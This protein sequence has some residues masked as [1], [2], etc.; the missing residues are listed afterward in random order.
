MILFFGLFILFCAAGA[1]VFLLM[2]QKSQGIAKWSR[3][4]GPNVHSGVMCFAVSNRNLF[5]GT[6]R[7]VFVSTEMVQPGIR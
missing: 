1:V 6:Y 7:G 3:T 4:F 2:S 5:A